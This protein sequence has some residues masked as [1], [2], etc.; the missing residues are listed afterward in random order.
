M[1]QVSHN[2]SV[3]DFMDTEGSEHAFVLLCFRF[4][5]LVYHLTAMEDRKELNQFT[6][7][8]NRVVS[9]LNICFKSKLG[10]LFR[11]FAFE[12]ILKRGFVG[13]KLAQLT[14]IVTSFLLAIHLL[15][16]N[17]LTA[18]E[19]LKNS[20]HIE[21]L[22]F[23]PDICITI[24]VVKLIESINDRLFCVTN[25]RVG[26]RT[27]ADI[28]VTEIIYGNIFVLHERIVHSQVVIL[29]LVLMINH[30]LHVLFGFVHHQI[31]FL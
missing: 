2:V 8:F 29:K 25:P 19:T 30:F 18:L 27:L 26:H 16:H 12:E 14:F 1:A 21:L 13:L 7:V 6:I 17:F 22:S 20:S 31:S 28:T 9:C 5:E 3:G 4:L 23:K 11:A 10:S 24:R 15:L